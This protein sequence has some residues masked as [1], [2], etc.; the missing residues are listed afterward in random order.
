MTGVGLETESVPRREE[1]TGRALGERSGEL[2]WLARAGPRGVGL[3]VV[4]LAVVV[5]PAIGAATVYRPALGFAAVGAL[6]IGFV[7]LRRLE[8]AG[9]LLV[10]VVPLLTGLRAGFPLPSIKLSEA[11]VAGAALVVLGTLR[12]T[13][14]LPWTRVEWTLAIFVVVYTAMGALDASELHQHLSFSAIGTLIGPLQ[15]FLIYRAVRLSLAGRDLQRRGLQAMLWASVPM[16]V[17]TVA[18]SVNVPGVRSFIVNATGSGALLTYSGTQY[19]GYLRSTG[20]WPQWTLLAG[21]LSVVIVLGM[22]CLLEPGA[23]VLRRRTMYGIM[24]LDGLALLLTAEL[25][26]IA[27]LAVAAVLLAWWSDRLG[28]VMKAFGVVVVVLGLAAGPFLVTRVQN[29]YSKAPGSRRSS[30][31]PQT[32]QYRWQVWTS[33][34]FPAIGQRPLQGWGVLLP[35]VISWQAT[36]SQYVTL[37]MR[38]GSPLVVAY[39]V[40]MGG[41]AG[42]GGALRRD[43]DDPLRRAGGRA[44]LALV[45][46]LVPMDVVFPYFEDSGMP[47]ALWALVGVVMAMVPGRLPATGL[48]QLGR[49]A[50]RPRNSR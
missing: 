50:K 45:V 46:I 18:Q 26:A 44:V 11:L 49:P 6:A 9:L 21:Y 8:L 42:A 10:G 34:Y 13:R 14:S 25:S 22:S 24:L 12:R 36:E 37:L 33:Q 4:G 20:L 5:G 48:A 38:G 27:G 30:I 32:I 43:P 40:M 35:P 47:E 3:L 2:G 15:F 41:L 29:E 16:S 17:L 7:L 19:S 1:T 39:I 31:V 23:S 28:T